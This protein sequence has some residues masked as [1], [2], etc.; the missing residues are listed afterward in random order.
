MLNIR[1]LKGKR[2]VNSGFVAIQFRHAIQTTG[3]RTFN[4]SR[5]A[6]ITATNLGKS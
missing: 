5:F 6:R 1:N 4:H 2:T 3:G